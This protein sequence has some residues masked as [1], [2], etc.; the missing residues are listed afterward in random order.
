MVPDKD[1]M[2]TQGK[3]SYPSV[4]GILQYLQVQFSINLYYTVSQCAH[5][6]HVLGSSH[7]IALKF[8]GQYLKRTQ[9]E[10]LILKPN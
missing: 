4:I 5:F 7:E 10:G 2:P 9:D 3:C 6:M 8:I 1:V